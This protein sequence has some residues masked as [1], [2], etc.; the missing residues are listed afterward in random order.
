MNRVIKLFFVLV[1]LPLV[2][3]TPAVSQ[4]VASGAISGQVMD[5]QDAAVA[6]AAVKLTENSF[7]SV[8]TTW[9]NGAG[10]YVFPAVPPGTYHV[11]VAKEGFSLAKLSSQKVD[12]GMSITMNFSMQLGQTTTTIEVH[13]GASAEL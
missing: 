9:T 3:A 2:C 1:V 6:G 7:K 12:V 4:N 13:A 8:T 11:T 5:Q 10:R